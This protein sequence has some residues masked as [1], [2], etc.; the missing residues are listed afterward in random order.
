MDSPRTV[1]VLGMGED[2]EGTTHV[3]TKTKTKIE[4]Y[5]SATLMM[6]HM[7]AHHQKKLK[8]EHQTLEEHRKEDEHGPGRDQCYHHRLRL[9]G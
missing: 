6:N 5:Q 4:H 2:P 3:V 7:N 1:T 8:Q 9:L